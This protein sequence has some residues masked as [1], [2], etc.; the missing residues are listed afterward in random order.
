MASFLEE[1]IETVRQQTAGH[2]TLC[3]LSG[4]VDNDL[5]GPAIGQ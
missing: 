1:A 4:G 3:A 2:N 5:Q